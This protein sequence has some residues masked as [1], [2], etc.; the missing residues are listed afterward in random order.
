[1]LTDG[2]IDAVWAILPHGAPGSGD[3]S[4]DEIG[5][6]QKSTK[7]CRTVEGFLIDWLFGVCHTCHL[8]V[9]VLALIHGEQDRNCKF[10]LPY[11]NL[12]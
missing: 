10:R 5:A 7:R 1:L 8:K 4:E 11:S 6:G 9:D 3:G 12:A 2:F